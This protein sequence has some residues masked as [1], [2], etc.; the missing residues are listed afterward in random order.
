MKKLSLIVVVSLLV[1]VF[2]SGCSED[3]KAKKELLTL[4][5]REVKVKEKL[6]Q[7]LKEI[8]QI[9]KEKREQKLK[10]KNL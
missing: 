7:V 1:G 5:E 10:E 6:E 3:K 2:F 4:E 8:D 9:R